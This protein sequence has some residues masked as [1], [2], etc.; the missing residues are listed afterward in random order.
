VGTPVIGLYAC[1]NP[2]RA[3]PYLSEAYTVNRYP[4]AVQAKYGKMPSQLPWGTRVREPGTMERIRVEDVTRMLDK[5]M[6]D[7][8]AHP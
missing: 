5:L 8:A 7:R 6:A 2:Q 4:E 1:T 3:R